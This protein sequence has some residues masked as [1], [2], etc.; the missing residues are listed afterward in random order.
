MKVLVQR[1]KRPYKPKL[2]TCVHCGH[3]W[4][5]IDP[6][7]RNHCPNCHRETS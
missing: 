4:R 7:Y 2:R 5:P 1:G 3:E 6:N